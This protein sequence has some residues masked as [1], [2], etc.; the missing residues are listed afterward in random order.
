[1][2]PSAPSARLL[3]CAAA[4]C[5][6]GRIGACANR[7]GP[8]KP[9]ARR[10]FRPARR[11]PSLCQ[12]ALPAHAHPRRAGPDRPRTPLRRG[13]RQGRRQG[14]R[15][16]VCRRRSPASLTAVPPYSV[17][18]PS[19]ARQTGTP[20]STSS[21]GPPPQPR[22][23]RRTTWDSPGDYLRRPRQRRPR[24]TCCRDWPIHHCM[25]QAA[26]LEAGRSRSTPAPRSRP[27]P[28]IAASCP[29]PEVTHIPPKSASAPTH[30][31][32]LP[33]WGR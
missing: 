16:V 18:Q 9:H 4:A 30:V 7:P 5:L 32:P 33:L 28:A 15:R 31:H 29:S 3:C 8:P 13:C 17:A 1:M 23:D 21:P 12:P 22:W 26:R 6:L 24:S 25:A 14:L 20:R 10:Y 27:P 11:A 2:H 19:P